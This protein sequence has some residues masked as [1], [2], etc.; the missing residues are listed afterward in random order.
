MPF[1]MK[2]QRPMGQAGG[3]GQNRNFQQN[4]QGGD[5]RNQGRYTKG[6]GQN[7]HQNQNR[8]PMMGGGQMQFNNQG[9]QF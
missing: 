9:G 7:Q 4:K 2:Q 6:Y 8:N 3:P 1:L 5:G